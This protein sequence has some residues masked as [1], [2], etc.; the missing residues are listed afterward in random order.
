MAESTSSWYEIDLP[1]EGPAMS[2]LAEAFFRDYCE[3]H[4]SRG[5]RIHA[6]RVQE[7]E[8]AERYIVAPPAAAVYFFDP[9]RSALADWLRTTGIARPCEGVPRMEGSR[10]LP[11]PDVADPAADA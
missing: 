11:G 8:R 9:L 7:S 6:L 10:M 2:A 3:A 4:V 5:L 1:K